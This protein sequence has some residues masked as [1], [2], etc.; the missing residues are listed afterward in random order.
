MAVVVDVETF[1]VVEVVEISTK[2]RIYND[3][4]MEGR[5]AVRRALAW[6]QVDRLR[7]GK[8]YWHWLLDCLPKFWGMIYD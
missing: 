8:K 6:Q 1:L 5:A 4:A 3:F 7:F 2:V